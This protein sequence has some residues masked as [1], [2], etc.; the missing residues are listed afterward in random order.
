MKIYYLAFLLSF[1]ACNTKST[2]GKPAPTPTKPQ[3]TVQYQTPQLSLEQAN[4][5]AELPLACVNQEYPN[6]LSQTLG[7]AGDLKEPSVLHPTFYGCFDWHSAV[8]GHW[9]MVYLLKNFPDLAKAETLKSY[10]KEHLT[11]ENIQAEVAYFNGEHN[12]SYERTYGWAWLLKLA[13]ELHI[14]DDPLARE[15][16]QN[17]QPLTDLLVERYEEFLPKLNYPVRV[18]EH[19]NTAFGMSFAY[20]YAQTVNDTTFQKLLADRARDFYS[21]DTDCPISWEPGGTDFLSP[22][23]EELNMMRL[24][25]P[26]DEFLE[27]AGAFLPQL[28][29]TDYELAVGEV[30]DRT[31]GKLVH[32][33]GVNFSRA[34]NLYALAGQYPEYAHLKAQADKHLNYS[35]PNV[36]GDD[37]EGGHWLGSFALYA[38]KTAQQ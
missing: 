2:D 8:H 34:W 22:C 6:K 30:S 31:D 14:W 25:L 27:W 5:L 12:K 19:P 37:Y 20:E 35:L 9:S 21:K 4:N 15:L 17:L 28:S 24:V 29:N 38:L 33:D 1:T 11:K 23:L 36:V 26:K 13:E 7:D 18:G 32:L 10:L 16:E 3:D